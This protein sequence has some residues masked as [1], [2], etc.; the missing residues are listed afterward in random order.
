MLGD[1]TGLETLLAEIRPADRWDAT[2][3]EYSRDLC[4]SAKV[5]QVQM[6]NG[7]REVRFACLTQMLMKELFTRNHQDSQGR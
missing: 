6:T 2:L 3:D 4:S 7:S 5:S 1:A